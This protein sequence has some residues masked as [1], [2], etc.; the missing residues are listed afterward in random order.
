VYSTDDGAG[1]D[2]SS[3]ELDRAGDLATAVA[4]ETVNFLSRIEAMLDDADLADGHASDTGSAAGR[5]AAGRSAD[6]RLFAD[7]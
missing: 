4:A 7:S 2:P 6:G 5:L 1:A 3:Q